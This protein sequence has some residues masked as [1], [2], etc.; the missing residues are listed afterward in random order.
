VPSPEQLQLQ[1]FET[2]PRL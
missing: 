2:G 1:G